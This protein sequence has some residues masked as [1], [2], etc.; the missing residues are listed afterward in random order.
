[1]CSIYFNLNL[2][3]LICIYYYNYLIFIFL[4][5]FRR[6][7]SVS[8]KLPFSFCEQLIVRNVRPMFV[9]HSLMLIQL[10]RFPLLQ[11]SYAQHFQAR[12][13]IGLAASISTLYRSFALLAF[14][15][16]MS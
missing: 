10:A 16:T 14:H 7:H 8:I 15:A 6:F 11:L 13:V 3:Y 1:M 9:R 5:Y 12:D 4:I 2:I